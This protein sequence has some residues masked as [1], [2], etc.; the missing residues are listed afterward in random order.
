MKKTKYDSISEIPSDELK[1]MMI[2][3]GRKKGQ[4]VR[5]ARAFLRS[6]GMPIDSRG[7]ID[8]SKFASQF[9]Y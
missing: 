4:T 1:E 5:S 9:A 8:E 7:K 3:Y 6:I 2:A